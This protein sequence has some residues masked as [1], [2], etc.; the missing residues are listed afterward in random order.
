LLVDAR[1]TP[2]DTT[3]EADVCIV[4]AGAAGIALARELAG[5]R[6]R[7]CLLESGGFEPDPPTQALAGGRVFGR[8]YPRLDET[9]ARQFGGSTNCWQGVSAPL[10]ALDFQVRDWVPDSGWPLEAE[11]LGSHY[12]SAQRLC[13]LGPFA[14]DAG[15]WSQAGR[16]PLALEGNDLVSRVVQVAPTRFG[17]LYR[18]E[19]VRATNVQLHLFANVV[20][21]EADAEARSV[22]RARVACLDGNR[23]AVQARLF[24]LAAGGIENAR[25]LLV[26]NRVAQRG[27]GNHHDQLGRYFMEHP[28]VIGAVLLPSTMPT[29]LD[30]YRP[31]QAG[32]ALV[33]GT[34]EAAEGALHRERLLGFQ[35]VLGEP[36]DLPVFEEELS[37]VVREMD[38]VSTTAPRAVFL[39]SLCE[40]AP[41][42]ESRVRLTHERDALGVPRVQLEWRL[43]AL[44]KRSIRRAQRLLGR[45][46]GRSGLGRLQLLLSEDDH[47]WPTEMSGGRH[48]MGTTRMHEDPR[49]GVVD[50]DLRVHGVSNLYVAGSSVF[51]TS[52]ASPPTLTLLALTLRLAGHLKERLG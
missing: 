36:V 44:D 28:H 45:A 43:G 22:R 18:E 10:S 5:G 42:P 2:R 27:L 12:E 9:R 51:P 15:S 25:L 14:Y 38:A 24:V 48:H 34:L 4:G 19:L 47:A 6:A 7:V 37:Q 50:A 11:S 17:E 49:R 26:S 41:N 13:R 20:E 31:R 30:F 33:L 3:L 52:G 23:F 40:Q 35:T 39:M 16:A 32:P 1:S 21:L 29:S 46:L 8:A